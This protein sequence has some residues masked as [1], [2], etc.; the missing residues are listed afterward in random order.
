ME[1]QKVAED[2]QVFGRVGVTT[3]QGE[4][5]RTREPSGAITPRVSG[6]ANSGK[7]QGR[8]TGRW[9]ETERGEQRP[10]AELQDPLAQALMVVV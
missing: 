4:A 9:A 6:G 7:S 10:E 8:A 2:P 5:D 3:V 1:E